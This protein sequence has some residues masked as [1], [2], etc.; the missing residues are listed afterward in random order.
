MPMYCRRSLA[1]PVA[2]KVNDS[3]SSTTNLSEYRGSPSSQTRLCA[4]VSTRGSI[5][6]WWPCV[7]LATTIWTVTRTR[8]VFEADQVDS[9]NTCPSS[10]CLK[11]TAIH[12]TWI[13]TQQM[14]WT[15]ME[16]ALGMSSTSHFHIFT[17]PSNLSGFTE[18]RKTFNYPLLT[19]LS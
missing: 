16:H 14:N 15:K 10:N 11:K 8:K 18:R 4:T 1:I 13:S 9:I 6:R 12:G 3:M 17:L 7:L 19:H 5:S 2:T